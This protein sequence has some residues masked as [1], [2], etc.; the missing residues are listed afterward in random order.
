MMAYS[1]R[2]AFTAAVL[3]GMFLPGAVLGGRRADRDAVRNTCRATTGCRCAI[4]PRRHHDFLPQGI[5][6]RPD[7]ERCEWQARRSAGRCRPWRTLPGGTRRRHHVRPAAAADRVQR[8][9]E[10]AQRPS[11]RYPLAAVGCAGCAGRGRPLPAIAVFR[12]G[13]ARCHRRPRH[14]PRGCVHLRNASVFRRSQ[15]SS[16]SIPCLSS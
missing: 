11:A 8:R 12:A 10:R 7:V 2:E 16:W 13:G 15:A 1:R 14:A 4:S 9:P 6:G 5:L 3:G